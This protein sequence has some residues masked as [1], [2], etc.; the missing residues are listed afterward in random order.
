MATRKLHLIY[1]T[2]L[3]DDRASGQRMAVGL[4]N[5]WG[6]DAEVFQPHWA[7]KEP[8]ETKFERLLN[9]IDALRAEGKNVGL[10]GISAGASAAINAFAARQAEVVGVVLIAGKVNRPEAIDTYHNEANPA[11]VESANACQGALAK[12]DANARRR[13]LSRYGLYDGRVAVADSVIPGAH[14]RRVLASAHAFI[15]ASQT[16][17]GAPSFIRFLKRRAKSF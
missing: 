2:G 16:I 9:R 17:F 7:V 1:I 12:L 6:V 10:V 11:F 8:W 14:N 15:I 3:G 4:W 5:I 13:I